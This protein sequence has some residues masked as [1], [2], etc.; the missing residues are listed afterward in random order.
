NRTIDDYYGDSATRALPVYSD[1]WNYG[2]ACPGCFVQP[3]VKMTFDQSWHDTTV[4]VY[5][6]PEN[7]SLSFTGTAVWV[8]GVVPNYVRAA[9]TL[10]N[11][12]F[13]LDGAPAGAYTHVPSTAADY[14]YNV[15]L[16]SATALANTPHTLVMTPQGTA[17]ASYLA[18]DWAQY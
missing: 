9:N 8:Y 15:T 7:I 2:P 12:T 18:F 16:Y 14:M 10:V 3:D 13:E 5:S 17:Q 6:A 1:G 11:V 4:S